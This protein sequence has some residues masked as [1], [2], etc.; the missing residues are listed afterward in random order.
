MGLGVRSQ[1]SGGEEKDERSDCFSAYSLQGA[2]AKQKCL[3]H[4]ERELK[5]LSQS[6]FQGNRDFARPVQSVTLILS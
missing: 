5:A 3:A 6:R 1:E 4:L 2:G